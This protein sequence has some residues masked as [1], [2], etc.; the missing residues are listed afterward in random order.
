MFPSLH[1]LPVSLAEQLG[2]AR[3]PRGITW[4]DG[5]AWVFRYH[6]LGK[7]RRAVGTCVSTPPGEREPALGG[8][9]SFPFSHKGSTRNTS[10]AS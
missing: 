9:V 3:S 7:L 10:T 4:G 1:S 8:P 5:I 2:P 6:R